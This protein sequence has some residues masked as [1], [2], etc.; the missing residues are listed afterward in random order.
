MILAI[1][2]IV[3][4][5]LSFFF[6]RN[7]WEEQIRTVQK[8][9]GSRNCIVHFHKFVNGDLVDGEFPVKS[10]KNEIHLGIIRNRKSNKDM[11]LITKHK[12]TYEVQLNCRFEDLNMSQ[13]RNLGLISEET[14]CPSCYQVSTWLY[15]DG[16]CY[17][18]R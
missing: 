12:V 16:Y 17:D 4:Y 15:N 6:N 8:E 2:N 9:W 18:C 11:I 1:K 14:L 3:N 13:L 5:K 7:K 10:A